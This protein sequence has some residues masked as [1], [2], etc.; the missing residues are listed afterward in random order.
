MPAASELPASGLNDTGLK[1][2]SLP[3]LGLGAKNLIGSD[4]WLDYLM[5]LGN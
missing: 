1:A 5:W 4:V 2:P 3:E